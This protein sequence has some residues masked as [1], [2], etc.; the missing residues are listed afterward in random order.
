MATTAHDD[1]TARTIARYTR[2]VAANKPGHCFTCGR[3]RPTVNALVL[4]PN[5]T[6]VGK[7]LA[8]RG[9]GVCRP[10]IK[11]GEATKLR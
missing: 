11:A 1:I 10:C 5:T 3:K 4:G 7:P 9:H 2:L 8:G 6:D